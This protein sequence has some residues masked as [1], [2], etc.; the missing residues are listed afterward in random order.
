MPPTVILSIGIL[1]FKDSVFIQFKL[2]ILGM[3]LCTKD[4]KGDKRQLQQNVISATLEAHRDGV[5][6]S[7]CWDG[8]GRGQGK[9][10]NNWH[11]LSAH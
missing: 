7:D 9:I 6:S 8:V 10:S 3:L 2:P 4:T 11:V 1:I 5:L